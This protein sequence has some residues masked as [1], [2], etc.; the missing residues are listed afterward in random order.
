MDP[1]NLDECYGKK[2]QI[3]YDQAAALESRGRCNPWYYIIP[4]K[5]GAEI[6]PH[7]DKLLSVMVLGKR[8]MKK[9]S[10]IPDV[11]LH[12]S[13]EEEAV[14]LFLPQQFKAVAAI[15]KPRRKRAMSQ[16]AK[17]AATE[18]LKKARAA[19]KNR[20]SKTPALS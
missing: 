4:C 12:Q 15:V 17:D 10:K 20:S 5:F 16:T 9:V 6:Y 2:Y 3:T 11:R 19:R 14:Y 13:G 8:L 1:I 18:R 7:S